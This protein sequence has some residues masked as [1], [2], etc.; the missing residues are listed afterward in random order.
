M[1]N[2]KLK[3][4]LFMAIIGIFIMFLPVLSYGANENTVIVKKSSNEYIIYLKGYLTQEFSFAFSDDKTV[5]VNTL[6]FVS[7]AV[8]SENGANN[9]AY[10][11]SSTMGTYMWVKANGELKISAQEIDFT[12]NITIDELEKVG[13]I[14]KIIPIKIEQEQI[15][16]KVEESD[17]KTSTT[18]ETVGIVK[19]LKDITNGQYQLKKRETTAAS[20]NLFA[21]AELI[22]KNEFTDSYIK[23]KASKEFVEL[24]NQELA[25]LDDS[26]WSQIE[27]AT[28]QQPKEATNGE[29]YILWVKADNIKDVHFLTSI[30]TDK[31]T[32][33]IVREQIKTIL[34][35]TYD[36]N[37]LLIAL[38]VVIVAIIAVSIRIAILKKKEMSK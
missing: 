38:A 11:D 7:S 35:H 29:Q 25:L 27:D 31:E 14:S 28:I 37:T 20:E 12:D 6:T 21:L 5:E 17:T 15:V 33:E 2:F 10:A 9:I 3:I 26:K 1:K 18:T 32:K 8:D 22:E 19:I 16:N 34:P 24:Y 36:N 30:R 4:I 13:D 23:M